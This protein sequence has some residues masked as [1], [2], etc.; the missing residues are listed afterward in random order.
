ME[1]NCKKSL[2]DGKFLPHD[3]NSLTERQN[4][5]IQSYV[6]NGGNAI[7]ASKD[8]GITRQSGYRMLSLAHIKT[9]I[10]NQIDKE[11]KTQGISI[12][13]GCIRG[14]IE[15]ASTPSNIRLNASKWVLEHAGFGL[16]GAS[17]RVGVQAWTKNLV[18]LS[19]VELEGLIS[20]QKN[21]ISDIELS[22]RQENDSKPDNEV[23]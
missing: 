17:L 11:L 4:L 13:W 15:D 6:S 9:E 18:D 8:A 23:V 5:F 21:A 10:Q 12:A 2:K 7:N 19:E 16:A 20:E 14:L 1:L 3:G 22:V